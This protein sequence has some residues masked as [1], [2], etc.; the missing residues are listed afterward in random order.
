MNEIY[1]MTSDDDSCPYK[2]T[3]YT[4]GRSWRQPCRVGVNWRYCTIHSRRWGSICWWDSCFCWWCCCCQS[5][6]QGWHQCTCKSSSSCTSWSWHTAVFTLQISCERNKHSNKTFT[7]IG[8]TA[9]EL[10]STSTVFSRCK[11]LHT[12]SGAR[13]MWVLSVVFD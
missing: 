8:A 10:M 9:P 5:V 1:L 11:W 13:I 3:S 2:H 6:I 7:T 4:L 12:L